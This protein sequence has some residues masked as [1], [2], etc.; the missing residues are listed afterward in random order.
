MK[1]KTMYSHSKEINKSDLILN[2]YF[3]ETFDVLG[4]HLDIDIFN[5]ILDT[6]IY[7]EIWTKGTI[8]PIFKKVIQLMYVV[9]VS[10]FSKNFTG[11][12]N[13]RIKAVIDGHYLLSDAQYGFRLQRSTVDATFVLHSS[14]NKIIN[15]KER[16][17][18]AFI[19]LKSAF[20]KVNRNGLWS[21]LYNLGIKG[22]FLRVIKNMYTSVKSCV[23]NC[24]N[25]SEYF[26]CAVGLR[27]GEVMSPIMFAM[28]INDLELFLCNDITQ[29]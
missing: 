15:I 20:D 14:V 24:N 8:I 25:Y 27:Q 9:L 11:I 3:M 10:C 28:F 23:R 7:P 22:K 2:E 18:C 6:G 29:F 4:G 21:K 19:D 1:S 5:A 26:E 16:L 12:L 17:Y 13:N